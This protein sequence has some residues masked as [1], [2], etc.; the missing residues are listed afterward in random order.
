MLVLNR[1]SNG[2]GGGASAASGLSARSGSCDSHQSPA[3]CPFGATFV[4]LPCKAIHARGKTKWIDENDA[5]EASRGGG[6][7]RGGGSFKLSADAEVRKNNE[8]RGRAAVDGR[9][10]G[11]VSRGVETR[12]NEDCKEAMSDISSER[13]RLFT[14][15]LTDGDSRMQL[16]SVL[17]SYFF[18]QLSQ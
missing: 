5:G 1:D 18:M 16:G 9:Q 13:R 8:T 3:R 2:G 14:Y 15:Y 17:R 11:K 4:S 10:R 7:D 12:C 6:G